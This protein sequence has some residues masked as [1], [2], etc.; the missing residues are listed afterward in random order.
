M[1]ENRV[2][3]IIEG[4]SSLGVQSINQTNAALDTLSARGKQAG[5]T[6]SA[7]TTQTVELGRQG[8]ASVG[9]VGGALDA[10]VAKERQAKEG[11]S[12]VTSQTEDLGRRGAPA[13][14]QA[15]GA[16]DT[17][18]AKE[19]QAEA[20]AKGATSQMVELGNQGRAV[21]NTVA[22]SFS[23]SN[24]VMTT[25]TEGV[26]ANV[27]RLAAGYLTLQ[28][29]IQAVQTVA[30]MQSLYAS[31]RG[32]FGDRATEQL[33]YVI[34]AANRYGK[35][36]DDVAGSYRKFAAAADYVGMPMH[37]IQKIFEATTQSIT[38]VGGSSGDVAG[39]LLAIQQSLGKS[40]VM[41]EEFR[42]Q[43]AE[44]IPGAMKMGAD[45]MG[46]TIS[47]FQ[48]LMESGQVVAKDFW[49]RLADEMNK[50]SQGWQASSDTI[51]ANLERLKNASKEFADSDFMSSIVSGALK[52]STNEVRGLTGWLDDTVLKIR[53]IKAEASGQLSPF[54]S[55]TSS[56]DEL[57][58]KLAALDQQKSD[59]LATL[60]SQATDLTKALV[61]LQT[62]QVDFGRS[63]ENADVLRQKLRWVEDQIRALTGQT[64]TVNVVANVDTSQLKVAQAYIQ[65]IIKGTAEVK[66]RT[67]DTDRYNLEN[68]LNQVAKAKSDLEK[69]LAN[70]NADAREKSVLEQQLAG[71]NQQI[72]D[73]QL[74]FR[75][76]DKQK[77]KVLE[78][79]VQESSSV[80][81]LKE[82]RGGINDSELS[83]QTQI[84]DA[85]AL[86]VARQ[87]DAYKKLQAGL[88]D[89]PTYYTEVSRAQEAEHTS[90]DRI[91]KAIE[92][93]GK[94]RGGAA[95]AA[96]RYGEQASSYLQQASDQYEQ[97]QAQLNG[98]TLGAK[99]AAID[100][101]Y[102]Q[103]ESAIRKSM[104]GAKGATGDAVAA[105]DQLEKNRA[106]EKKIAEAN[107]WKKSLQ[108]ASSILSKLGQMTGDPKAIYA[109]QMAQAQLWQIEQ[110]RR[111]NAI[112]DP[113]ERAKQ[114]AELSRIAALEELDAR[115]HAYEGIK[116]I[117]DEY[118]TAERERVQNHLD[119]VRDSAKSELAYKM[120]EAQQWD[121]YN[122]KV[123]EN[124]VENAQTYAEMIKAKWA[125]AYGS[126]KSASGKA[127]DS[128]ARDADAT[129]SLTDNMA[130]AISG[131]FGDIVRSAQDGSLS[132]TTIFQNMLSRMADALAQWVTDEVKN[133]LKSLLSSFSGSM[134]GLV[135]SLFGG[136]TSLASSGSSV[137][138]AM[139]SVGVSPWT[140]AGGFFAKGGAVVGSLPVNTVLT[141]PTLFT[142]ADSGFRPFATGG[143]GL[144][145]EAGP[146][147]IMPAVRM[148]DGNYGTRVKLDQGKSDSAAT[149][150]VVNV[151]VKVVTIFDKA[152]V[153]DALREPGN[154]RV[155]VAEMEREGFRRQ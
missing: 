18:T 149:Q 118:W 13:V 30:S 58:K 14:N 111:V 127:R 50:F 68:A 141:S 43:F 41:A 103:A 48:K 128:W 123:L 151:P 112:A 136:G 91:T 67:L 87:Q 126:Y 65:E 99:L 147:V 114:Q 7:T 140:L 8:P 6:V 133:W 121:E 144:G 94:A 73:A 32:I 40:T 45:A 11:M 46:V 104:I 137:V 71:I 26:A 134:S 122:K 22:S 70:P 72:S 56:L 131:T 64:W 145:G 152:M 102:N 49:P 59:Y 143:L 36:I 92:R 76:L 78:Q 77:K 142:L 39:A 44:R 117:S 97:L 107:A 25:M 150:P 31:F 60:K 101:K 1:V 132:V 17:L 23:R 62:N 69:K 5:D 29:A 4:D 124:Q 93:E 105:L 135:G 129:I 119:A 21:A 75:E 139:S 42:L 109:G 146:E 57:R 54:E 66:A 113:G 98:D 12:S 52:F 3:I 89:L 96:A 37:D 80:K 138:S 148:T 33:Y 90:V 47:E 110:Q 38:K 61:D 81:A 9:R 82:S 55:W 95:N 34:A 130:S 88:V 84:S 2:R 86:S 20:A 155:I 27:G 83:K 100:K 24:S 15:S 19:K 74:G 116:A 106:I 125:L 120:Y 16:M 108:D 85:H 35:S 53:A 63:Q 28:S 10:V 79:Q 154:V 153:G 115:K 51:D